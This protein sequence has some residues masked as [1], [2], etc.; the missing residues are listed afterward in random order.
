MT[1]RPRLRPPAGTIPGTLFVLLRP[2][3]AGGFVEE[4]W[5][6]WPKPPPGKSPKDGRRGTDLRAEGYEIAREADD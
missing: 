2:D 6:W 1:A 4:E 3:G 5:R